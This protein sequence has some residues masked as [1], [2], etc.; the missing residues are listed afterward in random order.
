MTLAAQSEIQIDN[1]EVRV[2]EWRLAPGAATGPH[3]HGMDYVI[4]PVADAEMTIVAPDGTRSIA[5]LKTGQSYFRKAGVEHD[6]LNES[7][8][9][10]VFLEVELKA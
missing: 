8:T 6:V 7:T 9:E 10:I 1:D 2:T 4:V 5:Q 3:R